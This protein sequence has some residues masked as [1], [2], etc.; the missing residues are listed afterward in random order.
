M[1]TKVKGVVERP[2]PSYQ[3]LRCPRCGR[4]AVKLAWGRLEVKCGRCGLTFEAKVEPGSCDHPEI[5]I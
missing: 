2:D 4:L 5:V 3:P 1:A